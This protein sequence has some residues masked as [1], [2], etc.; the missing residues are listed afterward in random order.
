MIT[1]NKKDFLNILPI[2]CVE[3]YVLAYLR[4]CGFPIEWLY[5][6]SFISIQHIF[7]D[8]LNNAISFTD[9]PVVER[10]QNVAR[11]LNC[12]TINGYKNSK[13]PSVTEEQITL[14]GI[15]PESF[16]DIYGKNAWRDDHYIYISKHDNCNDYHYI[17]NN[18]LHERTISLV[19]IQDLYNGYYISFL[20]TGEITIDKTLIKKLLTNHITKELEHPFLEMDFSACGQCVDAI[21]I[22]NITWQRT[23]KLMELIYNKPFDFSEIVT[24]FYTQMLYM[25]SR[26]KWDVNWIKNMY[27][28]IFEIQ[29]EL[30]NYL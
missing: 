7:S 26:R 8:F 4:K 12:M 30:L 10:V 18:P 6:Q 3:S 1:L 15:K 17:N 14:I 23:A 13:F 25:N 11:D 16:S 28:K 19:E 9:Y 29:N 22:L 24:N 20:Y 5:Y 27:Q 2:S 21:G